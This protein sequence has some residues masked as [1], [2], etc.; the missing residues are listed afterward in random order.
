LGL[1]AWMRAMSGLN[2]R[3]PA[4]KKNRIKIT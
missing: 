3:A 2:A 1:R 4:H